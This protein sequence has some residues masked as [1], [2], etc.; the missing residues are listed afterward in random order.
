MPKPFAHSAYQPCS[1]RRAWKNRIH[2]TRLALMESLWEKMF[3]IKKFGR[4]EVSVEEAYAKIVRFEQEGIDIIDGQ[5][6]VS[7]RQVRPIDERYRRFAQNGEDIQY[8]GYADIQETIE[9][10]RQDLQ[11]IKDLSVILMHLNY[12]TG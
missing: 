1:E 7:A 11:K 9:S 3:S 2:E 4:K 6:R 8:L 10:A 12:G 5:F